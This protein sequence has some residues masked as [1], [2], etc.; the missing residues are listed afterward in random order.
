VTNA[1]SSRDQSDSHNWGQI[2]PYAVLSLVGFV[3]ALL[4]I[5]LLLWN[6]EKLVALGL[7]GNFYYL[8]LVPLGLSVAAFLFGA[9][10]SFARYRGKQF[11]GVLELGGPV[12]AF[13]LVLILGF[14][15][16]TP[17][18]NFP[19]TVYVHGT[20]GPQ[21]LILRGSGYI[22]ID[23]AGLRRK[24]SIGSDGEA[25]FPEVPANFRGQKVPV[26]LDAEDYELVDPNQR[27]HLNGGNVYVE[28]RKKPG[29]IKGYVHDDR[30]KPLVGVSVVAAGLSAL[31]NEVGYFELVI[32]GDQLESSMTLKAVASE[33]VPWSDTVV[34]NSNDVAI[35]LQ[36]KR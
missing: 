18:S 9:L 5:A 33:Y 27:A 8:V 19:L 14:W 4:L 32:P 7:T 34:P 15:L 11:G 24:A 25:F 1:G 26:L 36:R 2:A 30:G 3:C 22:L 20:G 23:T 16:P 13:L 17:A 28:V 6:A 35:A 10:R 31:S 21:D 12:V 29:H